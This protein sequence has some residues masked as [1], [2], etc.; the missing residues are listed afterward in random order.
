VQVLPFWTAERAPTWDEDATGAIT[1]ITQATTALDLFQAITDAG[2]H[3]LA[4]IAELVLK[5][6]NEPPRLIVSGG[7]QRSPLALQRLANVLG[8][9]VHPNDE[10]EASLRGAAIYAIEK[11]GWPA[12]PAKFGAAVEPDTNLARLFAE[13]RDRQRQLETLLSTERPS[14]PSAFPSSPAR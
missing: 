1:G 5:G 9:P 13:A 10:M 6:E 12:P 11:L 8:Q 14:R 7:I 2:Y 4:R 3:R